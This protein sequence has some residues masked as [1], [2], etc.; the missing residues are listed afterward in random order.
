MS[1]PIDYLLIGHATAD[2]TPNGR[3]LGGTVSYASRTVHSF[4][5]RVGVL[6]SAAASE[7]LLDELKRFAEVRVLPAGSTST[8]ENVYTPQGRKQYIRGVASQIGVQDIP[9]DWMNVPLVHLAPLTDEVD[10]QIAHRFPNATVLLTL[11]GWLRRW[12]A[13][14]LVHFKRWHDPAVLNDIDIVVFSEEDIV[15]APDLEQEFARTTCHLFVTRAEKGGTYYHNGAPTSYDTPQVEVVHPTGAGDVFAASLL[16]A[17]HLLKG[18]M[19]AATRVAA[20]LAANSVT[21]AGLASAPTPEE[22]QQVLE[23]VGT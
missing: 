7:P 22:V 2:L 8:F 16:S 5:L 6:T 17:L 21:R 14:G 13:D 9:H 23:K 1:I 3:V 4:G 12:G 11:Q 15:E 18:D 20:A 19:A 10:P